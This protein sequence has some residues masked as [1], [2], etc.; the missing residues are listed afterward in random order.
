MGS[1]PSKYAHL[2]TSLSKVPDREAPARRELLDRTKREAVDGNER[3][4]AYNRQTVMENIKRATDHVQSALR[5]QRH[6]ATKKHFASAYAAAYAD[7]RLLLEQIQNWES[8][9]QLLVDAFKELML[10]QM[11]QEGL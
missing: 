5:E 3:E 11:E 1:R 6:A 7:A 9:A 10:A 2:V 4:A 8:S